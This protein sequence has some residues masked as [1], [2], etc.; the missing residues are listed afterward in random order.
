VTTRLEKL[1]AACG[2]VLAIAIVFGPLLLE[3][4]ASGKY[5]VYR[6]FGPWNYFFD[7][8]L[9]AGEYPEWNPLTLGG[10]PFAAN[11]QT[12]ALYP[13]NILRA[14]LH[15]HPTPMGTM[16]GLALLAL[17]HV[18]VLGFGTY[19]LAR[20]HELSPAAAA[21]AMLGASLNALVVR[22]VAELHFI[23]TLAW[24]PF[25]LLHA[26][27]FVRAETPR[28]R[29]HEASWLACYAALAVLGGFPQLYPYIAAGVLA[30]VVVERVADVRV[31]RARMLWSLVLRDLGYGVPAVLLA[32]A[33]AA[34]LLLPVD[35]FASLS[36]RIAGAKDD[37]DGHLPAQWTLGYAWRSLA[38]YSGARYEPE[39]LRGAGIGV[40]ALAS[41]GVLGGVSRRTASWLV[42]LYVFIDLLIGEPMPIASAIALV[43]P[44]QMVSAT[45]A[46]DVGL[47]F[48]ALLAGAGL[49]AL[50]SEIMWR[51]VVA[52]AGALGVGGA[53]LFTLRDQMDR[54]RIWL[55]PNSAM[56]LVPAALLIASTVTALTGRKPHVA[57]RALPLAL[58]VFLAGELLAWNGPYA[59]EL[60]VHRKF[61]RE[62]LSTTDAGGKNPFWPDNR[63]DADER[64][65]FGMFT[66]RGQINGYD[67]LHLDGV[68]RFLAS[69]S[70]GSRYERTVRI[71]E[72][73]VFNAR[74]HLFMK[75]AFW[76]VPAVVVG[77]QPPRRTLYPPTEVAFVAQRPA[78]VPV[79]KRARVLGR[80]VSSDVTR[81]EIE[82]PKLHGLPASENKPRARAKTGWV[83]V[84]P[85]HAVLE[86]VLRAGG[87]VLVS[88]RIERRSGDPSVARDTLALEVEAK[89]DAVTEHRLEIPLPDFTT[90]RATLELSWDEA[91]QSPELL[92]LAV[93]SDRRDEDAK[94]KVVHRTADEVRVRVSELPA[95]RLLVFSDADY[96]DWHAEVDGKPARILRTA[97]VFKGV[98]LPAGSHDVRFYFR[99][100]RL[101]LGLWLS[102]FAFLISIAALWLTRPRRSGQQH[103]EH[104]QA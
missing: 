8:S 5:D 84:P 74:A 4:G 90:L 99:S 103:A 73:V 10:A 49:D 15:V 102:G 38:V 91:G 89:S 53:A 94:L 56:L 52:A 70:R 78:H 61:E 98:E 45:R 95:P 2:I 46:A 22:R 17:L 55:E 20:V 68:R 39:T 85:Q 47:V 72:T 51:R 16:A 83:T 92:S 7:R 30:Y 57:T 100:A 27:A 60:I 63:R 24:L 65:N 86:L 48:M 88:P 3:P 13:P 96:P 97:D 81:T 58:V 59:R 28:Q 31:T 19:R 11:P 87:R 93:L 101:H 18:C 29:L 21:I 44:F 40:L 66:L 32:L 25:I 23:F 6:A 1:L 9:Q 42:V 41:A 43:S 80:G 50:R 36:G 75:R 37:A 33:L 104:P 76:L 35:E 12:W 82:L 14:L 64:P 67:P 34:C 54:G 26:R 71:E 77:A 79:R 69:R 62:W